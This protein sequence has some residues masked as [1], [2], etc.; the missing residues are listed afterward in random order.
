VLTESAL[1][2]KITKND[3]AIKYLPSFMI[4]LNIKSYGG[5]QVSEEEACT[6][7]KREPGSRRNDESCDARAVARSPGGSVSQSSH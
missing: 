4:K 6:W 3:R 5:Q 2:L 7:L 1:V